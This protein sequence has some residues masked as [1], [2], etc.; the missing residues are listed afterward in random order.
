LSQKLITKFLL[1]YAAYLTTSHHHVNS[2]YLICRYSES[3]S[4]IFRSNW[5]WK[6]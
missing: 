5:T 6:T 3:L 4:F 2:P 1:F